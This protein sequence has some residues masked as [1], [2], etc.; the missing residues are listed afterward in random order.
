MREQLLGRVS[1]M[2]LHILCL[3]PRWL[4]VRGRGREWFSRF[5]VAEGEK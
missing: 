2:S 5:G 4:D 3:C 1:V